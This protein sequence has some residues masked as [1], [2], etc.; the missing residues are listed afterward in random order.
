MLATT[1]APQGAFRAAL[2][3]PTAPVPPGVIAHTAAAPDKRFAVYRNNVVVS[4]REALAAAFPVVQRIVGDEFFAAMAGVFVRAH[5]PTS[6]LLMHYGD[7]LPGFLETFP[8]LAEL[9]YLADVARLE[10]ARLRAFHAAD[11][12]PLA[13]DA[14]AALDAQALETVRVALLPGTAIVRS[15]HPIVTILAMN[16]GDAEPAPIAEWHGEDA[17]V[18]RDGFAVAVRRLPPG[19]AVFLDALARG[20]T[21]GAAANAAFDDAPDFDLALNL[22]GLISAGLVTALDPPKEATP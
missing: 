14:F 22:A 19:G 13:A 16:D 6:P 8:P 18:A 1:T 5:P 12:T 2:L 4:L 7:D 17:L 3:D 10:R 15:A 11:A 21:L 9:P 20:D